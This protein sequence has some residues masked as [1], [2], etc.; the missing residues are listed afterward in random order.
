MHRLRVDIDPI[1]HSM[2][3]LPLS[4]QRSTRARINS[5][6]PSPVIAART[7][8]SIHSSTNQQNN[9]AAL[10]TPTT[11]TLLFTPR[12]S[13]NLHINQSTQ[14]SETAAAVAAAS[15]SADSSRSALPTP[16]DAPLDSSSLLPCSSLLPSSPLTAC[17]SSYLDQYSV[18]TLTHTTK[19]L[20]LIL[21]DHYAYE[22]GGYGRLSGSELKGIAYDCVKRVLREE[23]EK[24][25]R[26]RLIER[27]K[28][29]V[30]GGKGEAA[31]RAFSATASEGS[32]SESIDTTDNSIRGLPHQDSDSLH[33]SGQLTQQQVE[34]Y[35]HREKF[36]LL[37]GYRHD[38][39]DDSLKGMI[40]FIKRV[41]DAN[42]DGQIKKREFC[43]GFGKVLQEIFCEGK[44]K[45]RKAAG[46]KLTCSIF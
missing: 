42:G 18:D 22:S 44:E 34:S 16:K 35:L 17:Y 8:M 41:I 25:V 24:Y 15:S 6:S 30:G 40:V 32:Q 3:L 38:C 21:F 33:S 37:P 20:I 46:M 31:R 4:P 14:S 12:N 1:P 19:S 13:F 27:M 29:E 10:L 36:N 2:G 43:A 5:L 23:G 28:H 9:H 11:Q 7:P 45:E 26:Q 39:M